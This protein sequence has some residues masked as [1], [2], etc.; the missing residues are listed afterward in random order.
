MSNKSKWIRPEQDRHNLLMHRLIIERMKKTFLVGLIALV[1]SSSGLAQTESVIQPSSTYPWNRDVPSLEYVGDQALRLQHW[2]NTAL[3]ADGP[4]SWRV[5]LPWDSDAKKLELKTLDGK[6]ALIG[7]LGRSSQRGV[8]PLQRLYAE[9]GALPG[10]NGQEN[11]MVID[12]KALGVAGDVSKTYRVTP[13]NASGQPGESVVITF[14]F[15]SNKSPMP[16]GPILRSAFMGTSSYLIDGAINNRVYLHYS[17]SK[18]P[19]KGIRLRSPNGGKTMLLRINL[20]QQNRGE[21]D[22]YA[23]TEYSTTSL[24][25][26]AG[27]TAIFQATLVTTDGQ[28]SQAWGVT[29]NV[30]SETQFKLSAADARALEPLKSVFSIGFYRSFGDGSMAIHSLENYSSYTRVRTTFRG[31]FSADNDK[32]IIMS[33]IAYGFQ[34]I[35]DDRGTQYKITLDNTRDGSCGFRRIY[36]GWDYAIVLS[37]RVPDD[38]TKINLSFQAPNDVAKDLIEPFKSGFVL[39]LPLKR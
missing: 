7:T 8:D 26:R 36:N 20:E 6:T 35:T 38:A 23:T 11:F 27:D 39:E 34:N 15:R 2:D 5:T 9:C 17:N 24:G 14:N 29:F 21:N 33:S 12:P 28:E 1:F 16:K 37:P 13:L 30:R 19:I 18:S 3:S 25:L 31:Q 4:T 22:W 10:L 32:R